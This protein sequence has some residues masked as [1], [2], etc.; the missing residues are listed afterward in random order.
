MPVPNMS[1]KKFEQKKYKQT[2]QHHQWL[3]HICFLFLSDHAPPTIPTLITAVVVHRW[4]NNNDRRD[5]SLVPA[6][7]PPVP[8]WSTCHS[9]WQHN[10]NKS[11]LTMHPGI[12]L[13]NSFFIFIN[14]NLLIHILGII[15]LMT[16]TMCQ[17]GCQWCPII[18][19][20]QFFYIY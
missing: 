1:K 8:T 11:A 10:D 3:Y 20:F 12:F 7:A 2:N 14:K 19:F 13:F 6:S 4:H 18:T 15:L 5:P 16:P 17:C 9:C